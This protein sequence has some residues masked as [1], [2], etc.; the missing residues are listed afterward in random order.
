MVVKQNFFFI[1]INKT[2][3]SSIERALKLDLDHKTAQEKI[4]QVGRKVWDD[5]FTFSVVRNPWDKVVSHY[6]YRVQTGQT[7]MGKNNNIGFNEW[8]DLAYFQNDS[9]YYDKPKMFMSQSDWVLDADGTMLVDKICRFESLR[10]DFSNVC[11]RLSIN[12]ELPHVK[13]SKHR[14]NNY[15]SYYNRRSI[16]IIAEKFSR[17]I[18]LFGYSFEPVD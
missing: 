7:G 18:E 6:S 8:V 3:G 13:A 10:E 1:H 4:K 12:T 2:G 15:Q 17:D 11:S 14:R 9:I 16:E 5:A